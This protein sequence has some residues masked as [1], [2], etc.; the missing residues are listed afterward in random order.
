MKKTT[1]LVN[2]DAP[3]VGSGVDAKETMLKGTAS[4]TASEKG[5]NELTEY[6]T[7]KQPTSGAGGTASH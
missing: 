2:M 5:S 6:V 7:P 3:G 4:T 1:D